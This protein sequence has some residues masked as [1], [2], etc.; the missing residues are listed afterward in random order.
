VIILFL[1]IILKKMK[2]F[3]FL[4]IIVT[5]ILSID[6]M[7]LHQKFTAKDRVMTQQLKSKFNYEDLEFE[8]AVCAIVTYM[9]ALN[10]IKKM[11]DIYVAKFINKVYNCKKFDFY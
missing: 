2:L 3:I 10:K 5:G 9:E 8:E 4:L 7:D 6:N 11:S 1:I